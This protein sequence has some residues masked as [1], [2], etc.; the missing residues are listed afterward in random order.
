MTDI[1]I[2]RNTKLEKINVI[3]QKIGIDEEEFLSKL[4]LLADRA[5]ED[6]CTTANPRVPLVEEIKQIL[7]DSYYGNE[8]K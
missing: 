2:A 7:I 5:F 8:I 4:D 1:E 6:Q 3:A